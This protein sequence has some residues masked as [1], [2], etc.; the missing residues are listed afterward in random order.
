MTG[1]LV[2]IDQ[3]HDGTGAP[4]NPEQFVHDMADAIDRLMADSE[5]AKQMGQAG[6]R[7]ARDQFSWE[8]IADETME[9]YRKAMH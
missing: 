7:R 5:R 4:T 8:S 1:Y 9:V 3:E 2:P 6:Y